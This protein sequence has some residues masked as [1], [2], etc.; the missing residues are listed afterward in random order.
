MLLSDFMRERFLSKVGLF[1]ELEKFRVV[2]LFVGVCLINPLT[3]SQRTILEI[4]GLTAVDL[5][6]YIAKK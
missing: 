4:C 2:E 5:R 6:S 3:K 1:L